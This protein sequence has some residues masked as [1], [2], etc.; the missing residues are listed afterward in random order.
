[1]RDPDSK[2]SRE[3]EPGTADRRS[4][5]QSAGTAVS[6]LKALAELGGAASLTSLSAHLGESPSKVH[7][8]LATL[9]D[10]DLALQDPATARYLLGPEAIT[11]GL[12]AMRQSAVLTLAGVE[13]AKL[14]ENH[15][16][17][18]FAA[19]LGN[20]G[21]T[22][23][24]W[25]EPALPVTVNVRVGSVLPVLW[26]ATG[27]AF[28]AF[29]G[30][31]L[32]KELAREELTRATP[33]RRHQLSDQRAVD[34]LFQEIRALRCAPMRDVLLNGVSAVAAP[35]FTESGKVAAVITALGPSGSFDP[36][37]G[38]STALLVVHA[39]E[40]VSARLGYRPDPTKMK[41]SPV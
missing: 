40:N 32:L 12:A 10:A 36:T 39:A 28:G 31:A 38:A 37:P 26:S 17:S 4:R 1:M 21:P 2:N 35:I 18:C 11:I 20:H 14:A 29:S 24:R 33:E 15:Q 22:I 6:V 19:V 3:A 23:V 16:L 9:V 8:Y 30:A 25:E 34:A 27:R 7:R 5:V 13:L 41:A